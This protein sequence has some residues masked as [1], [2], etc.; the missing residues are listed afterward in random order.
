MVAKRTS[1]PIA[2][3]KLAMSVSEAEEELKRITSEA[4]TYRKTHKE[5][6]KQYSKLSSKVYKTT[7]KVRRKI[8]ILGTFASPEC[9]LPNI[10]PY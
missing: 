8:R 7:R 4:R 5:I 3:K 10:I 6:F 9:P 2:L 1:A